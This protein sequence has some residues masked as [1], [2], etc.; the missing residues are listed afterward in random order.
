MGAA[1]N[2]IFHSDPSH[3]WGEVL[4]SDLIKYGFKPSSC[5]YQKGD[6]VYLEEDDDLG[7]FLK[8][9]KEAGVQYSFTELDSE[10]DGCA[11]CEYASFKA[12]RGEF[13]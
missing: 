1:M 10:D 13:K 4:R 11:C 3:G 12:K 2:I 9:L 6:K 5:S 7:G 8:K